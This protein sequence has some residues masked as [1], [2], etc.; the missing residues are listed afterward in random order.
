MFE[1]LETK[2][3]SAS[4]VIIAPHPD[5]EIIGC[6]EQLMNPSN[7]IMVIYSGDLDVKRRESILKLKEKVP[8]VKIQLFQQD[9]PM[10][11]KTDLNSFFFP[12]PIY[13]THPK[14]REWGYIGERMA[15]DGYNV[16]FYNTIMTAPYIHEVDKPEDKKY[17]LNQ[18]YPDQVSLWEYDYKYFLFEGYCKWVF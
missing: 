10:V 18:V 3:P 9:I 2:K 5:D 8:A 4:T 1:M 16:T 12:D 17:L 15:R 14:H 6:F 13:E 7:S 11:L